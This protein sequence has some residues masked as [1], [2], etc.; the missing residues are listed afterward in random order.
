VLPA[1][2]PATRA[3]FASLRGRTVAVVV[4]GVEST[5]RQVMVTDGS[6]EAMRVEGVA[7][8]AGAG[9]RMS[10]A[11][12]DI[13]LAPRGA[14]RPVRRP[15]VV[16]LASGPA[17]SSAVRPLIDAGVRVRTVL[18]PAMALG[19]L[20]RLRRS[21]SASSAAE[22]YVAVE[23][24]ASCVALVRD[25]AL[26][27]ARD[28]PWGYLVERDGIRELRT[29]EDVVSRLA[30]DLR[31]FIA[32]VGGSTSAVAHVTVCGGLPELR[33]IAVQLVERLDVEVEPLDSLFGIDEAQLSDSI[34]EF[35]ERGAELRLAWAAAADRPPAHNLLRAR[36]RAASHA[37]LAGAAVL[38]GMA[39]GLGVGVDVAGR[40]WWQAA[41]PRL[42]ARADAARAGG[43]RQGQR[44]RADARA[45]SALSDVRPPGEAAVAPAPVMAARPPMLPA[46]PIALVA[47]PEP[48]PGVEPPDT[49]RAS[50]V[51]PTP[52]SPESASAPRALPAAH[53]TPSR[54]ALP[55]APESDAPFD[56]ALGSILYAPDR[57]LAIV[58]G[59]IVGAGDEVRGARVVDIAPDVV[60][61]RDAR[62]RLRRLA[63]GAGGR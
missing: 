52:Q 14:G 28:L 17:L 35:R 26:M 22:A 27:A 63:L 38:A 56:A 41:E 61:L 5:H 53:G 15:V 30:D 36:R 46:P 31:E 54:A 34:H 32:D 6:Y 25:G 24:Q 8:L 2:G 50:P 47:A 44:L 43:V 45:V 3:H 57:R 21:A 62:G 23:E 13:A 18:T 49:T 37:M 58:D 16:A 12:S 7:A 60:L 1:A 48:A 10:G 11:W 19:S 59:R 39:A 55:R 4:W 9:L 29:R 33:S 51:R 20:A 40:A 42:A